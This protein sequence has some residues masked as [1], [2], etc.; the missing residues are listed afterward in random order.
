MNIDL[1]GK[2]A[3]VTGSSRGIG[4]A[5]ALELAANGADIFLHY[6]GNKTAAEEPKEEVEKYG[7]NCCVL[8]AD[9]RNPDSCR[10]LITK[11]GGV[12]ILV[13]N[14]SVQY[15]KKWHK[16]TVQD[17]NGQLNC[18]FVSSL[19]LIQMVALLCS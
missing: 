19:L 14:A 5:I 10:D 3:L 17:T 7:V 4:R 18:N 11:T 16:I 6:A 12:D 13:L 2:K 8:S 1:K 9:L 15:K